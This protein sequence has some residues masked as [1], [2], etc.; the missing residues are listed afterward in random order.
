MARW[1][2]GF[3]RGLRF[4]HGLV[5]SLRSIDSV[6]WSEHRCKDSFF[7]GAILGAEKLAILRVAP[8]DGYDGAYKLK[9]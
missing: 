6:R 2:R 7:G 8:C 1:M 4:V 3:G 9:S 5:V